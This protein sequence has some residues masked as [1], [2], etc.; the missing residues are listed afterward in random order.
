MP[1][2]PPCALHSLP[3]TN[4]Q[5]KQQR[6]TLQKQHP[7]KKQPN[8]PPSQET[9]QE[10][11]GRCSRPLST[12]QTTRN[13][14]ATTKATPWGLMSQT[15][16]SMLENHSQPC[17]PP[18]HTALAVVLDNRHDQG[19]SFVDGSTIRTPPSTPPHTRWQ[20]P[21]HQRQGWVCAP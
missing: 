1:R 19:W 16:N 5:Q 2:H 3:N 6:H 11:C 12:N 14:P 15:P 9:D 10:L 21:P 18:F 7:H 13:Q 17:R 4:T 8:Q 20:R